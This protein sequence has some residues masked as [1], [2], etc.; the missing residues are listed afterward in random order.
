MLHCFVEGE[1]DEMFFKN[2]FGS[3]NVDFYKYTTKSLGHVNKY[4]YSIK[5]MHEPYIFFAD[6]DGASCADKRRILLEKYNQ[7]EENY[8]HIVQYEIESWFLAG[9]DKDFC[10]KNK[11][12]P[13]YSNTNNVTKE[14]FLSSIK[15][16]NGTTLT[17]MLEI[18]DAY[19]YELA[20]CKN[21]S[22]NDFV[23]NNA[24]CKI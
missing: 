8:L 13:Y 18:L 3:C 5:A 24:S 15:E 17:L 19:D 7:L 1:K 22:F 9:I 6:A 14:M 21:I 23:S 20:K 2:M 11:I 10:D 12:K 4:I 16:Y